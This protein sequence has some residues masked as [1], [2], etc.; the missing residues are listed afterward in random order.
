MLNV[1]VISVVVPFH[2]LTYI[3]KAYFAP[4]KFYNIC[5]SGCLLRG[6]SGF[7]TRTTLG[8]KEAL[9]SAK[10]SGQPK[11]KSPKWSDTPTT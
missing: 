7:G 4:E 11:E 5:I 3:S 9:R 6:P 2:T 8:W 1:V 10:K